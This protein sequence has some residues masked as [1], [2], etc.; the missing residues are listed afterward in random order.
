MVGTEC[1]SREDLTAYLSG[2]LSDQRAESLSEHLETCT[3]CKAEL[4]TLNSAGDP[5]IAALRRRPVETS[6]SASRSCRR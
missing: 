5:L 6:I 1:P 2:G 3:K 4:E